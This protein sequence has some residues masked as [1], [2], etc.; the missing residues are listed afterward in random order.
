MEK[1]HVI[2]ESKKKEHNVEKNKKIS[3]R[4]KK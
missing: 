2:K 1:G 4:N 3:N